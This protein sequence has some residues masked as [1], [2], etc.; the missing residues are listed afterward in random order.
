MVRHWNSFPRRYAALFAALAAIGLALFAVRGAIGQDGE[1]DSEELSVEEEEPARRGTT[2]KEEEPQEDESLLDLMI[3]G[4]I[5]GAIIGILSLVGVGFAIEHAL[6]IRRSALIPEH[7]S[8]ELEQLI[9]QGQVDAALEATRQPHNASLFASI[10]EAALERYKGSEF[11]FAEYKA[12]AEEEGEEQTSKL[13][14]KTE[15]LGVI[16]TI[17]PMIGLLGTVRG[18]IIAFN[19]IARSGGAAEPSDLADGI[20]LA[21]VTTLQGLIVAIPAMV[22]FSWFRNRIDSLVSEAG[23]RVEQV[24]APLGRRR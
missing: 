20:R 22:A 19:E 15:V 5:E 2:A 10:V 11:G 4:G 14:R 23:K 8:Q 7:T 6:T 12:A 18:M 16:G 17:A 1:A 9:Q 24:L 3:A 13:Y 21:L